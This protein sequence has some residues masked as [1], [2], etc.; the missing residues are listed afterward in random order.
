MKKLLL[1]SLIFLI[2]SC[3][4][5]SKTCKLSGVLENAPKTTTLYLVDNEN[6][7][8]IDSIVLINGKIDHEF[9]LSNPKKILLH[10]ERNKYAF[11]DRKFIWLEPSEI[12]ITGDFEF[13][14][15]LKIQGS[16]SQSEFEKYNHF[17]NNITNQINKIKEQI[18]FKTDEEKKSDTIKIEILQKELSDSIVEF[19]LKHSDSYVTLSLLY[20]ECIIYDRHLNKKQIKIVYETLSEKL[21]QLQQGIAIRNYFNL[22]EPPK[23]GDIAPEITQITPNGDTINL[24]D[25]RG[26]LVLLD[27]W[28]SWCGPCRGSNKS[29]KKVYDK[30]SSSG[31][32]ILS[33]SGDENKDNWI[34]AIK[35][36]SM[37]WV[38]ISDLKGWHN[39]AF[40]RYDIRVIPKTFI[41]SPEGIIMDDNYFCNETILDKKIFEILNKNGL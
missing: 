5:E 27:F 30:Y 20:D 10:N 7:V 39:D 15:N 37:T 26:K 4:G 19:M 22:P 36:D 14:Q 21:K 12:L 1:I 13:I 38:Q 40:L 31:F 16:K 34:N 33:V 17:T 11:R 28:A 2:A 41:I 29:L 35:N 9:E 24:S 6:D 25:F 32:E 8:F 3:K 18:H 23:I